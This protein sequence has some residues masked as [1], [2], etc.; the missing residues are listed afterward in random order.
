MLITVNLETSSKALTGAKPDI[1]TKLD[2]SIIKCK[3]EVSLLLDKSS[4]QF[5]GL[6]WQTSCVYFMVADNSGITAL[7]G[8]LI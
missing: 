8:S 5:L 1:E 6:S 2:E 3:L 4:V 7:T